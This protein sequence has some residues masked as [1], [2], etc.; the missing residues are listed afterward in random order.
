VLMYAFTY[1]ATGNG[2]GAF[3]EVIA[4]RALGATKAQI[5]ELIRL[6]ALFGGPVGMNP[7]GELM[8]DY[9]DEWVDDPAPPIAWPPG[10]AP[11]IDAFRSGIDL[12]TDVLTPDEIDLIAAWH[13]R[14][15]GEVPDYVSLVADL[16]PTAYKTQRIR[17]EAAVT[18]ALPAQLLPLL[19]LHLAVVDL[20]PRSIRRAVQMARALGVRRHHVMATLFWATVGG[21]ELALEDAIDPLRDLVSESVT[22]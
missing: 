15:Y 21:G 5:V 12:T 18:G 6:A 13:R 9:L 1:A 20:G 3:Y 7:L 2:K 14:M 22:W 4:A 10:W 16:F 17:H 19:I 8:G 11:D